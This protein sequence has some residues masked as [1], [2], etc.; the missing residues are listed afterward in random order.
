VIAFG[1]AEHARD[2]SRGRPEVKIACIV[3]AHRFPAQV[4]CL[5]S[6]LRHPQVS[7][8]L[9]L[10]RRVPETPFRR[11]LA[12]TD[13]RD[14]VLL[15]RRAGRWGG[16]ELV[17]ASLDGLAHGA[18]DGCDYFFLISGQDFPLRSPSQLVAFAED[19]GP[20]SYLTNWSLP[21]ERWRFGGRD[22]TDFY[23]FTVLG[24]RETCFPRGEDVSSLSRKGRAL[25]QLLR[26]L[27][28]AK[29]PREFPTYLRPFGGHQWWNLSRPAAEFVLEF[30]RNHPEYRHYHGH[31]SCPDEIFFH[32]IL[33]GTDFA[34]RFEVVNDDLRFMIWAQ[35]ESHPRLLT[36]DDLPAML[37]SA[38]LFARKFDGN[39]DPA[40][41]GRL[42]EAIKV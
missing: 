26:I 18:R 4:V 31:T 25:N 19:A 6:S 16:I 37:H 10:D 38:D 32:S 39:L 8:Y 30:V 2:S 12:G 27:S 24:R 22:R 13:L 41:I 29:P 34:Q 1:L 9:H 40:V 28:C 5:L 3:L 7:T 33:L 42:S 35:A 14:I 15:P 17:D 11:K 21:T 20:R 23:T 36:V